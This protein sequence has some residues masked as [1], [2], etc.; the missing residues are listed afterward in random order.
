MDY[1]KITCAYL[2]RGVNPG[3]GLAWLDEELPVLVP[4]AGACPDEERTP[5][6]DIA[7]VA[8]LAYVVG[9]IDNNSNTA[10]PIMHQD[11]LWIEAPIYQGPSEHKGWHDFSVMSSVGYW[12]SVSCDD[13]EDTYLITIDGLSTDDNDGYYPVSLSEMRTRTE[14]L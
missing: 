4:E 5:P 7:E 8:V 1:T 13:G 3:D 6:R 2:T 12:F 14:G 11:P 10:D 9:A